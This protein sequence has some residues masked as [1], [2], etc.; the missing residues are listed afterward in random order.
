LGEKHVLVSLP[1]NKHIGKLNLFV[2]AKIFMTE[3]LDLRSNQ[4]PAS[5]E[6]GA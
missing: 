6:E 1:E 3:D 2:V 4:R 5:L